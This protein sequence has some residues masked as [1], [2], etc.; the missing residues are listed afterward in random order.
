MMSED[1]GY[2]AAFYRGGTSKALVFNR[3]DLPAREE[4]ASIFLRAMGSP[5]PTGRQLDGMGGGLSSLSKVCIVEPSDHP[6]A[7]VDFTFAQVQIRES[8]VDFAG[9]CGN[10]SAAIGPFAVDEALVVVEDGTATVRIRNVNTDKIMH[11]TFEVR[12]GRAVS[13]GKLAIPGVAGTGAPVKLDFLAPGGATTGTLLPAGAA[14]VE[15]STPEHGTFAVSMVDA[16]NACAF[17]SAEAVGL[18]GV[19]M[20][21]DL[22]RRGD[23][24][25][26]LMSIRLS[27]SVAMGIAPDRYTAAAR[28][29]VPFIAVV[30]PGRAFVT[31]DGVAVTGDESDLAIRMMSSG[32]PHRA[33]PMTGAICAAAAA[34]IPGTILH[35]IAGAR[36]TLRLGTPSGVITVAAEPDTDH[37]GGSAVAGVRSASIF[38]TWRRLFDGTVYPR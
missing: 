15:L 28:P 11:A 9:N 5:D 33:I 37:G 24:L 22:E 1:R 13:A 38:R 29:V 12:Q 2:R 8:V 3:A 16:A 17:V 23:V 18:T 7:D 27:A 6:D 36:P 32:Q 14:T 4:W 34:A 19:E 10:M 30:A 26:T 31:L 35:D 25:E 21:E 20:P